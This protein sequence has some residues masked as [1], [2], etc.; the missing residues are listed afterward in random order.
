MAISANDDRLSTVAESSFS[1]SWAWKDSFVNKLADDGYERYSQLSAS[2]DTTILFAGPARFS[3]IGTGSVDLIPIG[4]VDNISMSSDRGL[5]RLFEIGSARSFFTVGKTTHGITMSKLLADQA[6]ILAAL[7]ANSYKPSMATSGLSAPG[8]ET[9]NADVQMNLDSEVFAVPFGLLMVMKTR[10]G[11]SDGYGKV[12][13][14]MYLE[15]CHF[16]NYSFSIASTQ[17]V[18]AENVSIQYD[19]PVPVSFN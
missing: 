18:I 7:T 15:E 1:T 8:P 13:T 17:P 5:M 16:S 10:G 12:L 3:G 14:G 11:S 19:R 2:P 9:P 4:L 6:N